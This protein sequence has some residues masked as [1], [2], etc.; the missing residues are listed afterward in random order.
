MN[1]LLLGVRI[2]PQ[3]RGSFSYGSRRRCA[4]WF[5]SQDGGPR[6][7]VATGVRAL[8]RGTSCA[9]ERGLHP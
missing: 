2:L 1:T 4:V 6:F 8:G 5:P 3:T 7:R 9:E